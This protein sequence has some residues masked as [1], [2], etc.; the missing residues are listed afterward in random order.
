MTTDAA[1]DP[2]WEVRTNFASS[3]LNNAQ[4]LVGDAT[5]TA[6]GRHTFG[7]RNNQQY[8]VIDLENDAV[9][10][11]EIL[12]NAV[13]IAKIA[14]SVTNGQV[15]TTVGGTTVWQSPYHAIGKI[16]GASP[17]NISGASINP[18]G[19]G[20]YQVD[21]LSAASSANY[22]IQLTLK[23]LEQMFLLK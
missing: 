11:D 2:Q 5:N 10:T 19:V 6:T 1:G 3:T 9:E 22:V 12:N 14:P 20:N 8:R 23:T 21:F 4:I 7:G 16:N 18:I 15:L 17:T 13:T